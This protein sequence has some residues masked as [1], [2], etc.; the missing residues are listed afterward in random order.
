M[1]GL[2]C[3]DSPASLG[4][5]YMQFCQQ[6]P[7]D[8]PLSARKQNPDTFISTAESVWEYK[9]EPKSVLASVKELFSAP[10]TA[11][12]D[13][14]REV[15]AAQAFAEL[16]NTIHSFKNIMEA[17]AAALDNTNASIGHLTNTVTEF[18]NKQN[19]VETSL[20]TVQDSLDNTPDTNYTQR[21]AATGSSDYVKSDC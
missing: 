9:E 1:V 19:E 6:N 11:K 12:T 8:S 13:K 14:D 2:A 17:M 16:P 21:P 5:S 7:E 4:T 15:A 20:K 10:T 18:A 3:T